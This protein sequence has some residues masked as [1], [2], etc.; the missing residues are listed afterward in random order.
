MLTVALGT[1]N[2]T[3]QGNCWMGQDLIARYAV[4]SNNM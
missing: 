4:K 3:E 1:K 2:T